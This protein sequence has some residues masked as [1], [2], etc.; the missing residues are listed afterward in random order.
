MGLGPGYEWPSEVTK[1]ILSGKADASL[2]FNQLGYTQH[3]KLG[4]VEGGIIGY[5]TAGKLTREN[6]TKFSIIMALI[7][8]ERPEFY[9]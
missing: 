3:Q 6:F 9:K 4:A 1:L 7:H 5:L 2:A 8:L